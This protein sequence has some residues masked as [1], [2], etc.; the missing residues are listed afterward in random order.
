MSEQAKVEI[1]DSIFERIKINKDKKDAGFVTSI[2]PPFE[3]MAQKYPGWVKG[4][5]TI[6]TASSGVGKTKAAKF[7]TVTS[8]CE[9]VKK[10]KN[11]KVKIFYFAL[12]ETKD[13]F[14]RSMMSTLLHINYNIDISPQQLLS[15]GSYTVDDNMLQAIE[16]TRAEIEEMEKY[17]EVIDHIF[18]GYG[19]YKTVRDYFTPELG[20]YVKIDTAGGQLNGKFKYKDEDTYVFVV[21]DQINLLVPDKTSEY[22]E[23]QKNLHDAMNHYSKEYCLKQMCKRLDCVVVNIQQQSADKEKQE[24]YKGETNDKKL[25]PSLDGLGDNKLTQRDADIVWGLFAPTRYEIQDYRGY[26]IDRLKD[27]YRCL[28]WLKDRH[29][30]LG[31]QYSHLYFDGASNVFK[32]LPPAK[33]MNFTVYQ[34]IINKNF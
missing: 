7:F 20:E 14:W 29:Y 32:E 28:I 3:R 27:N 8:V 24:W 11:I 18:N 5:Y 4:T 30:G 31:N 9:F 33:D 12:E 22:G 6:L 19:I 10:Y 17:V 21:T 25:E 23:P 26:D 34:Q 2:S 16:T 1:F 15:L 13:M